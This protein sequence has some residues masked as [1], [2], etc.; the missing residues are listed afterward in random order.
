MNEGNKRDNDFFFIYRSDFDETFHDLENEKAPHLPLTA[1]ISIAVTLLVAI[2]TTTDY[3]SFPKLNIQ[4]IHIKTGLIIIEIIL[5]IVIVILFALRHYFRKSGKSWEVLNVEIV[6][7]KLEENSEELNKYSILLLV[8]DFEV[9]EISFLARKTTHWENAIFLPHINTSKKDFMELSELDKKLHEYI[10]TGIDFH[11]EYLPEMD[12]YNE[13]KYHKD[14]G[15]LR[16]YYFKFVLVYPKSN[17]LFDIFISDFK[18]DGYDFFK[19]EDMRNDTNTMKRNDDVIN[20]IVVNSHALQ[21]KFSQLNRGKNRLIWN[22]SENCDYR[23]EFC[24][25]DNTKK[26]S[27]LP[28]SDLSRVIEQL[29][30]IKVDTIDISTGDN[31]N[32]DYIKDCISYLNNAKY[33]VG[34]TATSKII[35]SLDADFILKNLTMIEFSYDSLDSDA[36]RASGYNNNNF[37]CVKKLSSSIRRISAEHQKKAVSF[38]ALVILY[39]HLTFKNFKKIISKLEGINVKDITLIRLMPVGAMSRKSYPQKLTDKK[40]YDD[41]IN[42]AKQNQN[43]TPH[44]SFDGI[45]SGVKYCNKGITK[46]SMSPSGN[47]Y[48]CPWA[49][50]LSANEKYCLGNILDDDIIEKINIQDFSGMENKKFTCE[51]FNT[52]LEEDFLYK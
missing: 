42:F 6:K 30:K 52:A 29:D 40:T 46:L 21:Q 2:L 3:I 51:I 48:S 5:V 22:I 23:C 14:E 19:L 26:E 43:I 8:P 33:K 36:H 16:R 27:S 17:F 31:V 28:L 37:M 10:I 24:A 44:C 15:C 35:E 7:N 9:K 11:Y 49:E 38:K 18:K 47:I 25:F 32:M 39:S 45:Y 41:Y 1:L 34:L 4:S 20:K 50:H 12:I 13:I